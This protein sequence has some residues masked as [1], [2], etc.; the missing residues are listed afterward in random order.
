MLGIRYISEGADSGYG[1]AA[2]DYLRALRNAGIPVTWTPMVPGPGWGQWLEPY[3]GTGEQYGG[4][5]AELVN[6]PI[7]YDTVLVQLITLY[8]P[9]W[10]ALEQGKLRVGMPVWEFDRFPATM[11]TDLEAMDAYIVPCR[12]NREALIASGLR[13]VEAIPYLPTPVVGAPPLEIPGVAAGDFMFYTV[14][15]WNERKSPFLTLA[16]YL[17]A[18]N[19][20]DR[21]VLVMKCTN[22]DERRRRPGRL[23]HFVL[24]HY[25]TVARDVERVRR[26]HRSGA[27]VVLLTENYTDAQ[28]EGLHARGDCYVALTRSEGWGLGAY[29]AGFAGKPVIMTGHGGQLDFLP[30]EYADL[31][32]FRMTAAGGASSDWGEAPEW[33]EPDVAAGSRL[34]RAAYENPERARQKGAA[35]R[36]YLRQ[37]FNERQILA[38]MLRFLQEAGAR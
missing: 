10:A 30:K 21:T 23:W 24:R 31:V 18:F 2:R 8:Y 12:W 4:E 25:H 26:R 38:K 20:E 33:A 19:A 5:F 16:S 32:P 27:R 6:R 11:R 1:R 28:I 14:S 9:R 22:V 3:T 37:E 13:Q 34:M 17:T 15:S 36:E 35:L 29:E 7:E